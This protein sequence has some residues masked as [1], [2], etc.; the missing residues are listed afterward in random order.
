MNQGIREARTALKGTGMDIGSLSGKAGAE[1]KYNAAAAGEQGGA[2]M[3]LLTEA[4]DNI[5]DVLI[6]ILEFTRSRQEILIENINS[7][8]RKGYEPKD[9]PVKEFAGLMVLAISEHSES[10]RL[11][12]RDGQDVKFASG[13]NFEARARVD[14]RAKELL[15]ESKNEYLRVQVNKLLENA[16][17]HRIAMKI[18]K[19]KQKDE[20]FGEK[21]SK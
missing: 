14:E 9:L 5:T 20:L 2:K 13:G 12:F 3:D 7:I 11:L 18:F 4:R 16:I 6:K 1:G 17:N 10:G 15:E 21:R 19:Q 8:R